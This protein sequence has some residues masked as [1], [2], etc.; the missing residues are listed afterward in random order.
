MEGGREGGRVRETER[1]R[2]KEAAWIT[3]HAR[4]LQ[5]ASSV[6]ANSSTS[7]WA[8][9]GARAG[10]NGQGDRKEGE[11]DSRSISTDLGGV[12]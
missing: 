9:N 3:A 11:L 10:G 1:E 6:S 5:L 12:L 7:P 4:T 2:Q 8:L